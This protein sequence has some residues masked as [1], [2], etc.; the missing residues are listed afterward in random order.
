MSRG[1]HQGAAKRHEGACQKAIAT[2]KSKV[3]Q[4]REGMDARP[5]V[6][7]VLL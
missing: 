4:E 6:S 7:V 1:V 2:I 3:Y 5:G